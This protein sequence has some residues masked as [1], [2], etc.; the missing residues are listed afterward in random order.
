MIAEL[1]EEH[2]KAFKT[3]S[4]EHTKEVEL[5]QVENFTLEDGNVNCTI[6]R[7]ESYY[8][9]TE[10]KSSDNFINNAEFDSDRSK[11]DM[12]TF[13]L[14]MHEKTEDN[15]YHLENREFLAANAIIS[16]KS[17]M[18]EYLM[19]LLLPNEIIYWCDVPHYANKHK[20]TLYNNFIFGSICLCLS[21]LFGAISSAVLGGDLEKALYVHI[22]F[23]TH[24]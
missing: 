13:K 8:S 7:D 4:E 17:K 6:T 16:N 23:K 12:E 1:F 21:V 10:S 19:S 11:Y 2:N 5:K 24:N 22:S 18:S 3:V 14:K 20:R 9:L 15:L